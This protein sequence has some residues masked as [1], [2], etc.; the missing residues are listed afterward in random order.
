MLSTQDAS[1][2]DV[3][4]TQLTD[5]NYHLFKAFVRPPPL[6]YAFQANVIHR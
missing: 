1:A 6:L 3:K 4:F 2:D 5:P